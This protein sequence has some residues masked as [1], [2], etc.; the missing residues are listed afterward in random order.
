RAGQ[1]A[2]H[3]HAV[4]P[5]R[6]AAVAGGRGGIGG[7][8][9]GLIAGD[10]LGNAVEIDVGDGGEGSI[11]VAADL[12]ERRERLRAEH[13][14][15]GPVV[16]AVAH[17]DLRWA[18][19]PEQPGDGRRAPPDLHGP[20]QPEKAPVAAE[21]DEA[22]VLVRRWVAIAVRLAGLAG[23]GAGAGPPIAP[24]DVARVPA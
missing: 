17:H 13:L 12:V 20:V 15:G 23:D 9:V 4:A 19:G 5:D 24:A 14:A 11:A 22:A 7:H 16:D 2:G 8:L 18:G 6:I 1:A 3:L 21:G 10:D